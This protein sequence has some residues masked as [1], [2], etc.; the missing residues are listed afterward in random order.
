MHVPEMSGE[1]RF[2][3]SGN[4]TPRKHRPAR[5]RSS[6]PGCTAGAVLIAGQAGPID[7]SGQQRYKYDARYDSG[8]GRRWKP[9]PAKGRDAV[10]CRYVTV[11]TAATTARGAGEHL[12]TA[13]AGV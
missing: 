12:L 3:G 1:Q 2:V 13:V 10:F 8:A 9:I 6:R 11:S 5:F 7:I 4:S